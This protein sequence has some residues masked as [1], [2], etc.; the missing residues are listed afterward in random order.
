MKLTEAKLKKLILEMLDEKRQTAEKIFSLIE[1][2]M[3]SDD[4]SHYEQAVT[5]AVGA[6]V[7][8]EVL[9][10]YDEFISNE[11]NSPEF[12]SGPAGFTSQMDISRAYE[13]YVRGR[14]KFEQDAKREASLAK[15]AL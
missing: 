8:N 2:S 7:V 12:Y 3:H 1:Q 10:V 6:K 13:E 5:L 9:E 4:Q 11:M 15:G 14:D